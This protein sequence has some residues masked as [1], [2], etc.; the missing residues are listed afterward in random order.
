MSKLDA[1]DLTGVSETLLIPLHYRAVESRSGSSL[2]KDDVAASI[3][4]SFR[5]VEITHAR[6]AGVGA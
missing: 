4:A 5:P 6:R 1:D 2:F 3:C